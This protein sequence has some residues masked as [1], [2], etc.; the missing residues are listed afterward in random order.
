MGTT[1]SM[2]QENIQAI[3]KP[4]RKRARLIESDDEAW[5]ISTMYIKLLFMFQRVTTI[6]CRSRRWTFCR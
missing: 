3:T 1:N 2:R 4:T 5:I 6:Q